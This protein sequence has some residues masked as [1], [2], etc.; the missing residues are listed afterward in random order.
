VA[1]KVTPSTLAVTHHN[2]F[3]T[4]FMKKATFGNAAATPKAWIFITVCAAPRIVT[5]RF[6]EATVTE[7]TDAEIL[8][9]AITNSEALHSNLWAF[10]AM[11]KELG[12]IKTQYK[13]NQEGLQNLAQQ[14]DQLNA[15]VAAAQAELASVAQQ[16]QQLVQEIAAAKKTL[17]DTRQET[18]ALSAATA[19]IRAALEAA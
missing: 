7:K 17:V 2:E 9:Q 6:K 8:D 13:Q 16:R 18:E 1:K 10:R 12:E 3:F 15:Q 5:V 4:T 19:Q 11:V 14:R